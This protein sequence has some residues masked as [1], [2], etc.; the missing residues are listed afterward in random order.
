[1][2]EVFIVAGARTPF[3]TWAK[4]NKGNGEPG[5]VLK[6][7]DPMSLAAAALKEAINRAGIE[8]KDVERVIFAN[9]YHA[10]PH[11]VYGGRYV[12]WRAGLPQET[13]GFS[14]NMACGAGLYTVM[15]AVNDILLGQ[16]EIVAATGADCPSMVPKNIFV[17]SF[18][19]ASCGL[20]IGKT[21]EN[22]AHQYGITRKDQDDWALLS[23][24]RAAKAQN[25]GLLAQEITA[26][27]GATQDDAILS[28]PNPAHFASAELLF[29]GGLAATKANTHGIVDGGAALILASRQA[30]EKKG[31][32]PL[33]RYVAGATAAVP[34][35]K[36]GLAAVPAAQK[37]LKNASWRLEDVDLFDIN[38]TFAGQ[39]LI[40]LKEMKLSPDK[41]NVHGG[42][43]ALG[44]PFGATGGRQILSLLLEL[45]R[46]QARRAMASISI[47][48]GQGIAVLLERS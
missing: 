44:H 10:G 39:I 45:K 47:G 8:G 32:K 20:P 31:L 40:D 27:N 12:A 2:Q 23:H 4:G 29:E 7:Y 19:D 33:G 46:R 13:P 48:A 30:V 22:L 26:V 37:A 24:E 41:V 1:M 35:E 38:E 34:P 15:T 25:A 18:H 21:V 16:A 43:I 9:S 11:A 3:A 5:G 28:S 6:D 14:V 36:M 17:P 42:A